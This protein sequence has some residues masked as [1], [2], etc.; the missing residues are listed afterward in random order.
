MRTDRNHDTLSKGMR[1]VPVDVVCGG[2]PAL[3][4]QRK[5]VMTVKR[6]ATITLFVL[7]FVWTMPGSAQVNVTTYH[8]DNSRTGQ[9]VDETILT[10]S[11]VNATNFGKLFSQSVDGYAYAQPLYVSNVTINHGTHNVVYVATMNDTVYAFDADNNTGSNAQPLWKV[12][13]TNAAKGITTVPTSNLHCDD[14]FSSSVGIFST[15]VIDT[16]TKTIYVLARTLESGAYFHRLHALDITTGKEKFGGPVAIT[17][18]APGSGSGSKGGTITFDPKLENQRSALLLM[19]GQVYISWA[20]LCDYSTYHGWVMAYNSST[21][22]QTAVWLIT[23]NGKQGGVWQSGDGPAGDENNNA[24]VAVG[25]GT[26]DVNTG[27]TDYGQSI[28]KLGHHAGNIFP[29][30]DYF[31][32][33]NAI[34]YNATDLDIGSSGLVLLPDQTS[35]PH[36]HLLVQGDK[37]GNLYLIN[38]DDM[39]EYNSNNNNQIVQYI[40]APTKGLWSS[41][42]WWNNFVYV[43][44]QA[45]QI[46]AFSFNTTTGLLSTTPSSK[47]SAN[48]GYPGT[49]VSIS[50]N[51]TNNGIVWALNNS[52]YKTANGQASLHAYKA[53]NLATQLYTSTTKATRDNPGAPIKFTVPTVAN[54][55]V[56]ITTQ[57]N[58]V[59][60]G[61]LE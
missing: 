39:G 22:A 10:T 6:F 7:V 50:S 23:P 47:T 25:N 55:K 12:N 18:S 3:P 17:A 61:L 30:V 2:F 9:N 33:F 49:T 40:V 27:G 26:F 43:G 32:P 8:N 29:I 28:V 19:N 53:T 34:T 20:S 1:Q 24:F 46:K 36:E 15:P 14:V 5:D 4:A 11:N 21:L 52:A 45:N 54:G 57:K 44:G 41:P 56:Y 38:R 58:L 13:F 59:V 51:D 42:S 31:T 48:F 60:Y 35:G 16:A 37:A